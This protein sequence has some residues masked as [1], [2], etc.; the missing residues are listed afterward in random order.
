MGRVEGVV[1]EGKLGDVANVERRVAMSAGS[2]GGPGQ[3]NLRLF[4]VDAMH[5]AGFH[6]P[7][8]AH[9]DGPRA[10]A[11]VENAEARLEMRHQMRGM[12][13]GA[14]AVEKLEEFLVIAHRVAGR[15]RCPVSHCRAF[16]SGAYAGNSQGPGGGPCSIIQS[17]GNGRSAIALSVWDC[18]RML[19]TGT[20]SVQIS[21]M[22]PVPV[23]VISHRTECGRIRD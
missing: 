22:P 14:A 2:G 21:G 8:E 3:A 6:C 1:L 23:E 5:L 20:N 11:E 15:V 19:P 10:A 7:G 9:R 13:L 18:G 16:L 4:H 17:G 12:G